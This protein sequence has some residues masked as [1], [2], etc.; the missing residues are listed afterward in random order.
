MTD[1][2]DHFRT[3]TKSWL[4]SRSNCEVIHAYN[5]IEI[6]TDHLTQAADEIERLRKDRD[7]LRDQLADDVCDELNSQ[8]LLISGVRDAI[9]KAL[10]GSKT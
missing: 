10:K 5:N 6:S 8:G 2:V 3:F 4:S 1:I 7:E 9:M